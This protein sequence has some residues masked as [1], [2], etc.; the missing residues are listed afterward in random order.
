MQPEWQPMSALGQ[1]RTSLWLPIMS[2]LPSKADI[3][4]SREM[5]ALCHVWTYM[6]PARLQQAVGKKNLHVA[7][8]V[9]AAMCSAC[10]CGSHDR[11]P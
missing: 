5:S 1:K 10:L 8:L 9:G 2:A 4:L 7:D 11:W 3:G 6:D